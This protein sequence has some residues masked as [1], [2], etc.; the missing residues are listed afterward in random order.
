MQRLIYSF[1]NHQSDLLPVISGGSIL[2]QNWKRWLQLGLSFFG[3]TGI[4]MLIYMGFY[5]FYFGTYSP[6]SGQIKHWWGSIYTVYGRPTASLWEFF[7]FPDRPDRGAWGFALGYVVDSARNFITM[8]GMDSKS[9]TLFGNTYLGF[10]LLYGGITLG[11]FILNWKQIRN[12]IGQLPI[13]PLFVGCLAQLFNYTG[14]N[15]VNTRGWYWI[16][17][18][19]LTV[20]LL[21]ILIDVIFNFL[22]K[23]LR[24]GEQVTHVTAVIL[25]MALIVQF[26]TLMLI[27]VPPTVVPENEEAYRGGM[28][29]LE[30]K[31]EP[32]AMIGSTGGGVIAYFIRDRTII[33]MDGLMNSYE[34][35][36]L[37]ETRQA[38]KYYNK[39]GLDYVYANPIMMDPGKL[40]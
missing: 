6:V 4:V 25:G 22:K 23:H 27:Q 9:D 29:I 12:Q 28:A 11:L 40:F 2:H 19:V 39:I 34:Y 21:A 17:E 1:A 38:Y 20:I 14:T 8:L 30:E 13:W 33:N 10:S 7:G 5:K 36:Q 18:M 31:T 26:G 32:G 16:A 15:Y 35:F 3:P 24:N 37:M